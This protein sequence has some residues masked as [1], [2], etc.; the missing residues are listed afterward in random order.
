MPDLVWDEVKNFFDPNLTG[1]LPDLR[2]E[3]ASVEDWQ[4]LFDL[5]QTQGWRWEYSEG[6][7]VLPLPPAAAVVARPADAETP[8]LRVWPAVD[9]LVIFRL[10]AVAEIDFDVNLRE[11][12]GQERLDIL[13]GFL[14]VI[15]RRLGKPVLMAPESDYHHPVLGFDVEADGVVLLADPRLP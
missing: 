9:V 5:V 4:A 1:S 8:T 14:A 10:Y 3:D 6:D 15:G 2:V 11:L 7:V 13:C 12:Q